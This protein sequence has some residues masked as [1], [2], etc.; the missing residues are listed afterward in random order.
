MPIP[1]ICPSCG[2]RLTAPHSAAGMKVRCKKCSAVFVFPSDLRPK[3]P[4]QCLATLPVISHSL[5]D[6]ILNKC[7][8]VVAREM[9]AEFHLNLNAKGRGEGGQ[10]YFPNGYI[11]ALEAFCERPN[12]ETSRKLIASGAANLQVF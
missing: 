7:D 8:F 6:D 5:L 1:V 2:Q 11:E 4:A 3:E 12:R 10:Y 9:I